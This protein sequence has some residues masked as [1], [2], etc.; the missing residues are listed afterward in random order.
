MGDL[1]KTLN[2]SSC[3]SPA[4]LSQLVRSGEQF[5][6]TN[7]LASEVHYRRRRNG[8]ELRSWWK[9]PGLEHAVLA[10]AEEDWQTMM[11][12]DEEISALLPGAHELLV[13][14]FT[15]VD[16]RLDNMPNQSLLDEEFQLEFY[17][18]RNHIWERTYRTDCLQ[19]KEDP[20][21]SNVVLH[22]F[23]HVQDKSEGRIK[24]VLRNASLGAPVGEFAVTM[25]AIH[26]ALPK[27]RFPLNLFDLLPSCANA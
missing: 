2:W 7:S 27:A 15:I 19:E 25:D 24:V 10:P 5:T 11:L 3:Y 20:V 4:F 23:T 17:R 6:T 12:T 21:Y 13:D 9:F 26:E 22:H 14:R 16:V 8:A 1:E 18:R